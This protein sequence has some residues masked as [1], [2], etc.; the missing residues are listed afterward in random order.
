MRGDNN[1][2]DDGSGD[3]DSEKKMEIWYTFIGIERRAVCVAQ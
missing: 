1:D 3:H 2:D